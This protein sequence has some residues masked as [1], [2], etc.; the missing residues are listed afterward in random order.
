MVLAVGYHKVFG[1]HREV[2][3]RDLVEGGLR[4]LDFGRL[5]FHQNE[6]AAVWIENHDVIP[7]G[8][9]VD[10]EQFLHIDERFRVIFLL[11]KILY[12]VLPHP[13]FGREDDELAPDFIKNGNA[14]LGFPKPEIVFVE[15]EWLHAA[16][17]QN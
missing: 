9:P 17:K 8:E 1:F 15:V 12:D 5:A 4:E 7:F 14:S 16:K 10:F 2:V 13:F 3:T 6:N 11:Q